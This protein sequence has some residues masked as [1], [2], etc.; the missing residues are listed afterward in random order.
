ML[1]SSCCFI[2]SFLYN[3]DSDFA[4]LLFVLYFNNVLFV[5]YYCVNLAIWLLYINKLTYLLIVSLFDTIHERV[6]QLPTERLHMLRLC[7]ASHGN[8]QS[9][10][11]HDDVYHLNL[12][13]VP[14]YVQ[15]EA[16]S[17]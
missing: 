3:F 12:D 15:M 16:L 14:S 1:L 4:H 5:C 2:V 17:R 13:L 9:C 6:R 11:L 10:L 7:I 8:E